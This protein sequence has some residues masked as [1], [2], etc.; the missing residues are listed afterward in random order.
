MAKDYAQMGYT[1]MRREDRAVEDDAWIKAYLGEAAMGVLATSYEGQPFIN[2]NLFVYDEVEHAIYM[3][4][5]QVGRTRANL[6]ANPRVCFHTFSMGRLLP[7]D[8]ALEFS[9]EYAGVMVF[10]EV[11]IVEENEEKERGL[12]LLL[13]KYAPHLRPDRDYRSITPEEL[14]RTA[15]YKIRIDEWV[16]KKKEVEE[17]FPGAFIYNE[18]G[19]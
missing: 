13:D 8:E 12:Q 11:V 1:E 9:V 16:G 17:D 15:V 7:A 3:H 18:N 6:D 4:T 14:K 10:G 19:K 5:A 2:S